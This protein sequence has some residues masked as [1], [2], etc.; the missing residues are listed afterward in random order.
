MKSYDYVCKACEHTW[1]HTQKGYETKYN[2]KVCPECG[3][4]KPVRQ[5]SAPTVHIFYSPM[6]PRH[7]RGMC[8]R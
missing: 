5:F 4:K 3:A 8:K 2:A 7:K 6:H 1:I